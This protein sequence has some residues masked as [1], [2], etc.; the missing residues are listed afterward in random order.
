MKLIITLFAFTFPV[1]AFTIYGPQ[2]EI[3]FW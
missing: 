1:I 3:S 2:L